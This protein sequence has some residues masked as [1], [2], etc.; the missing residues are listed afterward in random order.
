MLVLQALKPEVVL[1]SDSGGWH[2]IR[3]P[4]HDDRA[5]SGSYNPTLERYRCHACGISG[6]GFDLIQEVERCDFVTAR[7]K[8]IEMCGATG[9]TMAAG[10]V[11]GSAQRSRLTSR[12]TQ[13]RS[14]LV[15]ARKGR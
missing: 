6:D 8:A 4:F 12:R 10:S 1:R 14:R 2:A 15:R 7:A 3:C 9:L 5:A 11:M 13:E